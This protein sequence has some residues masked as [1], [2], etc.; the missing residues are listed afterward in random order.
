MSLREKKMKILYSDQS[1]ACVV[2]LLIIY[3]NTAHILQMYQILQIVHT[4][5]EVTVYEEE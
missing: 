3:S 1:C 2:F 5:E 4:L